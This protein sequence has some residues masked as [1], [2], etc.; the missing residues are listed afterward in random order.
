M[1]FLM[2]T[3]SKQQ[4]LPIQLAFSLETFYI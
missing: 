3:T 2:Y 4:D 1:T